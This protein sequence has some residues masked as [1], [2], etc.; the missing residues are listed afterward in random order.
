MKTHPRYLEMVNIFL[1]AAFFLVILSCGG[2]DSNTSL[3]DSDATGATL[4]GNVISFSNASLQVAAAAENGDSIAGIEVSIGELTVLTDE[5]G[6]FYVED[7]PI[8]DQ[9]IRFNDMADYFAKDIKKSETLTLRNMQIDGEEIVTEHTGTW[10][11]TG[12]STDPSSQGAIE[13]TM[14]IE[15]NGNSITGTITGGEPD[16]S[17]WEIEGTENGSTIENGVVTLVSSISDCATG[18][19]FEGTFSGN[20]LSGTFDEVFSES[21]P[22][23]PECIENNENPE[24]GTF[25]L[26]KQP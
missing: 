15:K 21:D 11:G 26:E 13:L 3:S 19:T 7:V 23:P 5:Q 25:S 16:Y 24:H 10:T 18:G 6:E 2:G 14:I 17:L 8:G 12:G 1:S 9:V 22:L 20:T 4:Q